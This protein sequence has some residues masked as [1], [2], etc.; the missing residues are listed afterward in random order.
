MNHRHGIVLVALSLLLATS[1]TAHAAVSVGISVNIAPPALPVYEQPLIPGPGYMWVPG[2]WAWD[3][4]DYYWVPGTWALPPEVGF[5]WT[6]GYWGWAEGVYRWHEGYWGRHVGFYGGVNYGFGYIGTGYVG[7]Y[8]ANGAFFYNR[9]VNHIDNARI[10]NVYYKTVINN[11][12]VNRVSY[13]GGSGGIQARPG[14]RELAVEHEHHLAPVSAQLQHAQMAR[15][16]PVL[17]AAVN[18]GRPAIAA[19]PRAEAFERRDVGAPSGAPARTAMAAPRRQE[20]R[21]STAPQGP[22]NAPAQVNE[23]AHVNERAFGNPQQ[24]R[25]VERREERGAERRTEEGRG[26]PHGRGEGK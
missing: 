11:V 4:H 26:E 12:T 8:W 15:R 18:H 3:G 10:S 25:T 23:P 20:L 9:A 14:A 16:D 7:G 24:G 13:N 19:T 22:R 5:L 6:P 17:H 2:Y 21:Q 1:F